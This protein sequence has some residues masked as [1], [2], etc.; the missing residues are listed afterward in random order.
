MEENRFFGFEVELT[1]I[2]QIMAADNL[3][4]ALGPEAKLI[5]PKRKKR[6]TRFVIKDKDRRLWKVCSDSSVEAKINVKSEHEPEAYRV[7]IVTPKLTWQDWDTI[8]RVLFALADCGAVITQTC[9]LH[10]HVDVE[11]FDEKALRQLCCFFYYHE[12]KLMRIAKTHK[13]RA[14]YCL[15]TRD[16]FI[17]MIT[18]QEGD[19]VWDLETAW[20]ISNFDGD[21]P[22]GC[23]HYH[24]SRYQGFNL[25]SFFEGNGIEFRIFNSSLS[26]DEVKSYVTLVLQIVEH[27]RRR[28]RARWKRRNLRPEKKDVK[29]FLRLIGIS[30]R[31]NAVTWNTLTA[32]LD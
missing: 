12:G 8:D 14:K 3:I 29:R 10:V 2:T 24:S 30:P 6:I 31:Q 11:D 23:S 28:K 22:S 25:H 18:G 26:R 16:D 13:R 15:P 32:R 4:K 5:N 1:G 9:G 7:E 27:C 21:D 17:E 19:R 20:Y